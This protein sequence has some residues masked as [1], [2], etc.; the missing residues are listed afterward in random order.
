MSRR[1]EEALVDLYNYPYYYP[2]YNLLLVKI[3]GESPKKGTPSVR[4][5]IPALDPQKRSVADCQ[6]YGDEVG[7]RVEIFYISICLVS[8]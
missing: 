5:D 1:R 2:Y 4:T 6:N 3:S 7:A 8:F